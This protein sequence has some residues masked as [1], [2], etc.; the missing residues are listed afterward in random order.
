MQS[1]FVELQAIEHEIDA[2]SFYV[3]VSRVLSLIDQRETEWFEEVRQ[4][5]ARSISQI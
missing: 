5:R 2:N 4:H 1:R 3:P